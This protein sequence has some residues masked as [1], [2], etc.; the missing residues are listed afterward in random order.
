MLPL[1]GQRHATFLN[2][3]VP[4]VHIPE[5][6]LRRMEQAGEAGPAEGVRIAGELLD[7]LQGV[8]HIHGAYLMPQFGRYDL[9]AE[10]I[11]HVKAR[12]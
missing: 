12:A 3:E 11:D 2:N 6:L 8:P 1:F 5:P 9:A 4:G 10:I 7:E